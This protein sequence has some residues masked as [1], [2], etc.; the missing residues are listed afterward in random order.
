[1][2][3]DSLFNLFSF[4]S[5]LIIFVPIIVVVVALILKF[6]NKSPTQLS[7]KPSPTLT[8]VLKPTQAKIQ[9]NIDLKGPWVCSGKINNASASAFIKEKK[10]K[11]VIGGENPK[12][13]V[14]FSGDCLYSW[15]EDE[16]S[17]TRAC[18][19]SPL[20]SLGESMLKFG[21]ISDLLLGQLARLGVGDKLAS[22]PAEINKLI[23][24]CKKEKSIDEETFTIPKNILFKNG[25]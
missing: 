20:L 2:E 7:F 4:F 6:N 3:K 11:I 14:L 13:N 25:K 19:L 8:T 1:M 5:K 12:K 21:G 15:T 17:G 22:N 23:N 24:S 16:F 18:G 10:I 9:F